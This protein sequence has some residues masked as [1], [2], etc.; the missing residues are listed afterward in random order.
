MYEAFLWPRAAVRNAG[1]RRRERCR[2]CLRRNRSSTGRAGSDVGRVACA[3]ADHLATGSLGARARPIAGA[4][5][6]RVEELGAILGD[7]RGRY[8]TPATDFCRTRWRTPCAARRRTNRRRSPCASAPRAHRAPQVGERS[9]RVGVGEP[10]ARGLAR[11]RRWRA[12]R[13]S[14][15]AGVGH[16]CR[17]RRCARRRRSRTRH[18]GCRPSTTDRLRM[19]HV[20]WSAAVNHAV[21]GAAVSRGDRVHGTVARPPR[22]SRVRRGPSWPTSLRPQHAV[23]PSSMLAQPCEARAR[24]SS[25][26][27]LPRRSGAGSRSRPTRS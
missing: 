10:G 11:G 8:R 22:Q 6:D 15:P 19:A 1:S 12:V 5:H 16:A 18:R 14:D 24:P 20:N 4:H 25:R 9:A 17:R 3:P 23:L 26:P 2:M 7:S 27:T 13:R 21:F